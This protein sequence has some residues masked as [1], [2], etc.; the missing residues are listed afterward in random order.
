VAK[1]VKIG[2]NLKAKKAQQKI[3]LY[4]R[5]NIKKCRKLLRKDQYKW[6]YIGSNFFDYLEVSRKLKG[7]GREV[8]NGPLNEE[9]LKIRDEYIE[10]IGRL[11]EKFTSLSWWE[12]VISEK[13]PS[14]STIFTNLCLWEKTKKILDEED[15]VVVILGNLGLYNAVAD[16]LKGRQKVP[17][18]LLAKFNFYAKSI[19]LL[20]LKRTY[21]VVDQTRKIFITK[22]KLRSY[23]KKLQGE[24]KEKPLTVINSWID[25]R[26]FPEEGRYQDSYFKKL[27]DVAVQEGHNVVIVPYILPT[28]KYG[29]AIGFIKKVPDKNFLVPHYFLSFSDILKFSFANFSQIKY[30]NLPSFREANMDKLLRFDRWN[31]LI[32]NRIC[33]N[34]LFYVLPIKLKKCGFQVQRVIYTFENQ[35]WEKVYLLGLRKAFPDAKII[36]YQHSSFSGLTLNYY[37]SN[38]EIGLV[39]LPD[40]IVAAGERPKEILE[41][42]FGQ[43]VELGGALRYEYLFKLNEPLIKENSKSSLETPTVLIATSIEKEETAEF[44]SKIIAALGRIRAKVIL[45]CHP[46]WPFEKIKESLKIGSLPTNFHVSSESPSKLLKTAD[47]LVATSTTMIL[48]ALALNVP[49]LTVQLGFSIVADP[50]IDIPSTTFSAHSEEEI[51]EKV[52]AI[53]KNKKGIIKE[54][55]EKWHQIISSFFRFPDANTS[56]ALLS[57]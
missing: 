14:N 45:K 20:C 52:E 28:I 37:T 2:E 46:A 38:K 19:L 29:K 44:L 27:P 30:K 56:R 33:F 25:K 22:L 6:A 50:L 34:R 40:K 51:C 54:N 17:F 16:Y 24:L 3:F 32:N 5:R 8:L 31:D 36:G 35:T 55:K 53:L 15:N 42:T 10:Y 43:R 21:F 47:I 26:S 9:A 1:R 13:Q 4:S 49:V 41:N 11:S 12:S 23:V 57:D 7:H 18:E 48:E 39:P